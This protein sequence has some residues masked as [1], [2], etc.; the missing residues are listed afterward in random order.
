MDSRKSLLVKKKKKIL[1]KEEANKER[2]KKKK[3][4]QKKK[5]VSHSIITA[6]KWIF[7]MMSCLLISKLKA[8]P[9][10][11]LYVMW[12]IVAY[13]PVHTN[14]LVFTHML[15]NS[16]QSTQII[17][18]TVNILKC[19]GKYPHRCVA[20]KYANTIQQFKLFALWE[21]GSLCESKDLSLLRIWDN[22]PAG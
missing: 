12:N 19:S 2:L 11:R 16:I 8:D 7:C 22:L 14:H 10:I 9:T 17:C 3:L 15:N 6:R 1:T 13:K 21:F 4:L 18:V 20:S 5:Y